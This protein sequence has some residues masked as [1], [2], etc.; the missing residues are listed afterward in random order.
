MLI[1]P[2]QAFPAQTVVIGLN[3]QNCQINVYQKSTGLFLDLYLS[4]SFASSTYNLIVG[5]VICENL[6]RIVRD[7]YFGFIGD[8]CWIDQ[9]GS[10]DPTYDEIGSRYLLCYLLPSEVNSDSY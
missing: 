2:L 6:V 10:S 9:H 8:L 4:G 1:V 7:T 3:N 5:G